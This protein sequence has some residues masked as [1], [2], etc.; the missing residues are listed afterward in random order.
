MVSK[1]EKKRE[2]GDK[3]EVRLVKVCKSLD[4]VALVDPHRHYIHKCHAS[5]PC[6]EGA[7]PTQNRTHMHR[8]FTSGTQIRPH[9]LD[10][11]CVIFSHMAL[12]NLIHLL[13]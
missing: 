12:W 5:V 13:L 4:T 6:T 3:K 10:S 7:V 2:G 9:C 8:A 11:L 1:Y